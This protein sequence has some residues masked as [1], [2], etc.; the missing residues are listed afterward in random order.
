MSAY[1]EY[2][3]VV[4]GVNSQIEACLNAIDKVTEDSH[5]KLVDQLVAKLEEASQ[6][7]DQINAK[8]GDTNE[9]LTPQA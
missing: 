1:E 5:P 7:C 8:T 2:Y 9:A 4:P 6:L 3:I